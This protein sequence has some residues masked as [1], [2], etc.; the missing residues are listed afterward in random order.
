MCVCVCVCVSSESSASD[1][2]SNH[3]KSCNC[4]LPTFAV[5]TRQVLQG[6]ALYQ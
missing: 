1:V 2:A 3:N 4:L 5:S 6:L